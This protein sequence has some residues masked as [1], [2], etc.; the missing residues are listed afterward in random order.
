M[1]AAKTK[2]SVEILTTLEEDPAVNFF[3]WQKDVRTQASSLCKHITPTGLLSILLTDQQWAE[4]PS[5]TT[6]NQQGQPVLAQRFAP[7]AH[8]DI[9]DGMTSV[10]LYVAKASNDQLSE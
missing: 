7:P 3:P 6:M 4:F 5:N 10:A 1:I 2:P 8:V 9:N